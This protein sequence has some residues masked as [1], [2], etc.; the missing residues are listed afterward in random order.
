MSFSLQAQTFKA[1]ENPSMTE[2]L[3]RDGINCDPTSH[4]MW[5]ALGDVLELMGEADTA[6]ECHVT[7]VELENTASVI[8]FSAIPK[9]ILR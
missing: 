8:P 7:A 9:I 5:A 4:D 6:A 1:L 2:K 3:L